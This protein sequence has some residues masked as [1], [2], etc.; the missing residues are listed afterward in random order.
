MEA[1]ADDTRQ[2]AWVQEEISLESLT[3]VQK[4][5]INGDSKNIFT[6]IGGDYALLRH[7]DIGF[8]VNGQR[9]YNDCN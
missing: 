9:I 5:M 7:N 3:G 8:S 4:L 2:I 1:K 6:T